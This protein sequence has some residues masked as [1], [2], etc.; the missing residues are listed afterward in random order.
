MSRPSIRCAQDRAARIP[1]RDSETEPAMQLAASI[2][3]LLGGV[4]LA[5]FASASGDVRSF[6]WILAVLGLLGIALWTALPQAR[7]RPPPR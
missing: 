7:R 3:V 6:G 5:L 2:L 1:A 4:Y